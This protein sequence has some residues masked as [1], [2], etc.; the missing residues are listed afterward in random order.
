LRLFTDVR[1]PALTMTAFVAFI[2]QHV[3]IL[4][5]VNNDAL[6]ELLIA[7]Q[8][9]VMLAWLQFPNPKARSQRRTLLLLGVLLGL[10]LLTKGTAY[11]MVP[12]V[13]ALLLWYFRDDRPGL[14][15]AIALVGGPALLLGL[16]WWLRNLWVYP[17]FDPLGSVAHDAVVVGQLRTADW[18][19]EVGVATGIGRFLTTTFRSFWGQFGWMA[20]PMPGWAYP[21]LL[22]FAL[23]SLVGFGLAVVRERRSPPPPLSRM[24]HRDRRMR[25]TVGVM[26]ALLLLM[27]LVLF[28]GYNASFVQH[29]GRYLFPSLVPLAAGVVVGWQGLLGETFARRQL[30]R[31]AFPLA[32]AGLLFLL[33]LYALFYTIVPSLAV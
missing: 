18:L 24:A 3:A 9:L 19:A 17:G 4:S 27:N 31:Y 11:L 8:L 2:P 1:W 26:L 21:P 20:V 15:R 29:Q 28:V 13:G 10:G 22:L 25:L 12:V 5:A 6:A 33:G 7:A 32:L 16:V 30:L 23:L 14:L